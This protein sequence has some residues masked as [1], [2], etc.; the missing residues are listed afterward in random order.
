MFSCKPVHKMMWSGQWPH[1]SSK[2]VDVVVTYDNV[3]VGL[4][5]AVI[6]LLILISRT[7]LLVS[8]V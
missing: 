2:Y 4:Y 5:L 7:T 3:T 6:H 8:F 1:M